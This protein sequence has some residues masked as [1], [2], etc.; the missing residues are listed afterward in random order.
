M[1][2]QLLLEF[3]CF[4]HSLLTYPPGNDDQL[5]LLQVASHYNI[6][7]QILRELGFWE[8]VLVT[9]GHFQL[10]EL[11]DVCVSLLCHLISDLNV[12]VKQIGECIR[13]HTFTSRAV[14]IQAVLN[15]F[16]VLLVF[17]CEKSKSSHH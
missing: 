5:T 8:E 14:H 10:P 9:V 4:K 15:S 1:Q 16:F 2:I 17:E 13:V 6:A 11:Y 7:G 3:F 12:Y